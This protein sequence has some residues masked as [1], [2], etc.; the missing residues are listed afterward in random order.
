MKNYSGLAL[1]LLS[2]GLFYSFT[3][4]MLD[5]VK[6]LQASSAE[7]QNVLQNASKIAETRDRL[8]VDYSSIPREDI[9]QLAKALPKN[10]DTVRLAL[11]LDGIAARYG[12]AIKNVQIETKA[13]PNA[14][15]AVLPDYEKP[16][17]KAIVTFS[18]VSNYQNFARLLTDLEKSLRIMDIQSVAFRTSDT[19]LYDHEIKVETYWLK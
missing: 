2:I 16:Y 18:F 9:A 7:Y 1:I 14:A 3:S 19:G 11:D 13:D 5:D 17:N 6:A 4:P 8:L 15:L 10:I 12:I